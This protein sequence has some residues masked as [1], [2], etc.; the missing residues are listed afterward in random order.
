L[1]SS[2]TVLIPDYVTPLNSVAFPPFQFVYEPPPFLPASFFLSVGS[3]SRSPLFPFRGCARL[4]SGSIHCSSVCP[5]FASMPPVFPL[6]LNSVSHLGC[7]FIAQQEAKWTRA[8][9]PPL[10]Y[11]AQSSVMAFFGSL[12]PFF[13]ELRSRCSL[14]PVFL[15]FFQSS[16]VFFMCLSWTGFPLPL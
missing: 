14:L 15:L 4:L 1:A 9:P 6:T 7:S 10:L 12:K 8:S 5:F 13:H 3:S 2:F 11:R 16:H